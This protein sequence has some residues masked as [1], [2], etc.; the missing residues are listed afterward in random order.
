MH[1]THRQT[2]IL[3]LLQANDICS[4]AELA[5]RFG[6]SEETVRRDVRHLES[7]GQALKV[8]GG[9]RLAARDG[10]AAYQLRIAENA[11]M[12]RRIAETAAGLVDEGMTILIDSGTTSYWLARALVGV[13]KLSVV[14]N[15]IEVARELAGRHGSHLYIGGGEVNDD[16]CS[17]FGVEAQAF[18]RKF[19][20]DIAFF[21]IGA[22]DAKLG[23]LDFHL[24]EAE[25]KRALAPLAR[26]IVVLADS[27]KFTR[28]GLIHVFDFPEIDV[29]VT[30]AAPP[31][32]FGAALKDVHVL[33]AD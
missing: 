14:T 30:D 8:H 13:K 23:L 4:I 24:P 5:D 2:E 20:P 11:P 10:E 19:T 31:A 7:G 26:K 17:C 21:S 32:E 28:R 12:K 33:T 6:V 15:A 18:M 9:V 27:T 16:Y 22:I 25:L 29:L 1:Q 3:Q